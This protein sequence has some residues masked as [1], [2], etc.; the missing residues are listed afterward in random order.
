VLTHGDRFLGC[1]LAT[2]AAAHALTPYDAVRRRQRKE[3]QWALVWKPSS[4]TSYYGYGAPLLTAEEAA[5][6]ICRMLQAYAC[7]KYFSG[8]LQVFHMDVAKVDRDIA[9]V[10]VIVHVCCKRLFLMF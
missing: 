9:Y 6:G 10:K 3:M 5:R 7:F 2:E 1:Q 4:L 8:M